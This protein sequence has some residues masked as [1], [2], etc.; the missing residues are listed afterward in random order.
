MHVGLSPSPARNQA[1]ATKGRVVRPK[2]FPEPR[3][4]V[5][6]QGFLVTQHETGALAVPR[7]DALKWHDPR[8]GRA[9]AS[10][11]NISTIG[12]SYQLLRRGGTLLADARR[13]F[14]D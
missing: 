13:A 6:N 10:T 1:G 7:T 8:R 11:R 9:A 5:A 2:P 14:P 4:V 12:S 3:S